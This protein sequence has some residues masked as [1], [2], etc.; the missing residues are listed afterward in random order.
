MRIFLRVYKV[1]TWKLYGSTSMSKEVKQKKK[2]EIGQQEL[3]LI[4]KHV[5]KPIVQ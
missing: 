4:A 1:E 3:E 2:V 5:K